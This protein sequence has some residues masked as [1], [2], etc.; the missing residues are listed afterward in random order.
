M[1][2]VEAALADAYSRAAQEAKALAQ[3]Q[4]EAAAKAKEL[5]GSTKDTFKGFITD[6]A[7][8]KSAT[9]RPAQAQVRAGIS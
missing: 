1:E 9:D 6:L 3:S 2:Q 8:G 7:N 5:E 4:R